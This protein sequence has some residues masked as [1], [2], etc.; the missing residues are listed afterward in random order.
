MAEF[1]IVQTH[2]ACR[3]ILPSIP[4]VYAAAELGRRSSVGLRVVRNRFF[5]TAISANWD[6]TYRPVNHFGSDLHELLLPF[7]PRRQNVAFWLR[8]LKIYLEP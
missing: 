8:L 1:S 4:S 2:L 7:D 6:V 5:D 3:F